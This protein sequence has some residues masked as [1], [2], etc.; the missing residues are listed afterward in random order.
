MKCQSTTE[1]RTPFVA[2]D[3]VTAWGLAESCDSSGKLS[4]RLKAFSPCDD[5]AVRRDDHRGGDGFNSQLPR[6][7]LVLV[8][9][10]CDGD[11]ALV[12]HSGE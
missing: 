8:R 1:T 9:V 11:E 5:V 2:D 12:D 3:W 10:D 4:R 6:E 7:L